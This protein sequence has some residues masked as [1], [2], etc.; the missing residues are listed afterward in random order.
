MIKLIFMGTPDFSATVLKGLLESGQYEILAVVTQPDRAVGRKKEIRMT[1]VKEVALSYGLPIYQPEKLSGSPEMEAIMNLGAD[2]IVTAAFGQFLPSKL[3]ASMDFAVNVH[4]SLLPK[5]RGG[6]P[7]HYA[8]IQGDEEA[9]VTI[10]E[11]VK[12]MD[13]GDM[14]SRRSIPITDEDNVGTLF[15]KLAIVGRD[16][17]LDTLPAYLAGDIQPEAQDPS[18]VT[19]SPNIR[20]EEE[21]LDWTKTNRQL[22]NQIRGMNPWPVAHTLWQG[23]RFKIYEAELADGDGQPGEILE[24]G[25]RQLLVATGEGALALKTVQPAG[26][27]KMTIS[28]FL[29]GAGR[30]L[31]VGDKFGN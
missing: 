10:M 12:E 29:N 21:R 16:L 11:M 5:H 20:P 9:G 4:A 17:L 25:K 8:L 19:F 22:F 23:G 2:G 27:P 24:I 15:E 30:N 3:L 26:K 13:A 1:P 14:I 31:A 18:Q 6:A 7:I 28:D